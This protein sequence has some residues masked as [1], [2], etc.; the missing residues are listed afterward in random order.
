MNNSLWKPAASTLP[1][2]SAERLAELALGRGLQTRE[3]NVNQSS[4]IIAER[5]SPEV[6]PVFVAKFPLYDLIEKV[7]S[8]GVSHTFQ[9][10][11]AFSQ[12]P[13]P[14]T[15]A[16]NGVV[17]DDANQYL[18][19]TTNIAMVAERRGVTLK[20]QYAGQA[21]GGGSS[22]LYAREVEGG[23]HTIARD[24]QH[25]ILRWQ[26]SDP[27]S[28]TALAANGV[29]DVN[30][31]NGLRYILNNLAPPENTI[32][33]DVRAPYGDQRVLKALR[34]VANAI[35]D[36]GGVPDLLV[37]SS[38][39]SEALFEDQLS[40]VRYL[41]T[42]TM[43]EIRPGYSVRAISTDE[44]ELP[45]LKVPGDHMGTWTDGT[46]TYSDIDVLS[47][48]TLSLPYL[49]A[50]EPTILKIPIGTDGQLRELAIPFIMLGFACMV[51]Q[52]N[53]RVSLMI[54]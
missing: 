31:V 11:T 44:G 51:P 4:P 22:D 54:A 28:T 52:F 24:M 43:H 29:Y 10:W 47:T 36:K 42:P 48:E 18:R 8:N 32:I 39:G 37:T 21:A 9:Q 35:S 2:D 6:M 33:V 3:A 7:P 20:A 49:G 50:P 34:Y 5:L 41:A 19:K 45:V 40:Q 14:H 12:A 46:H 15:I 38:R 17:L 23:L 1:R 53:G 16:E 27:T 30:G 25:E 26:E 13:T